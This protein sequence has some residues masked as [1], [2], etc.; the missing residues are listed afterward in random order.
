MPSRSM[1][2]RRSVM[3]LARKP[4]SS[5][6]ARPIA[7]RFRSG[8][9]LAPTT[10]SLQTHVGLTVTVDDLRGPVGHGAGHPGLPQVD[11][12]GRRSR[13]SSHE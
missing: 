5:R 10:R 1:S 13:W 4:S 11:R 2:S 8:R 12:H 6:P 9:P 3:V 7:L